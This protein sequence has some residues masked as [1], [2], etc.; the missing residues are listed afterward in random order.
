[1]KLPIPQEILDALVE[2]SDKMEQF[3]TKLDR[4]IFLL[5]KITENQEKQIKLQI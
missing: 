1:M 2:S 5:E 4:V 3:G